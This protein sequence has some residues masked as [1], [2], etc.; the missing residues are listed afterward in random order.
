M[1]DYSYKILSFIVNYTYFAS[2]GRNA[3]QRASILHRTRQMQPNICKLR[4]LN[5]GQAVWQ[6]QQIGVMGYK[7]LTTRAGTPTATE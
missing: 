5:V 6:N 1:V 7:L 2:A 4:R 3:Y